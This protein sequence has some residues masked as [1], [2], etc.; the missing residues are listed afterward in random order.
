MFSSVWPFF[1]K[2]NGIYDYNNILTDLNNLIDEVNY[3]HETNL[4]FIKCA[5]YATSSIEQ[6][7][8]ITKSLVNNE[9]ASMYA[10]LKNKDGSGQRSFFENFISRCQKIVDQY[11]KGQ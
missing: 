11:I 5:S 9:M 8:E 10:T 6:R 1:K 3:I 4:S 7:S 2:I